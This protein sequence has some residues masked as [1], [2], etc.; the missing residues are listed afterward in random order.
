MAN[1]SFNLLIFLVV[2]C[3]AISETNNITYIDPTLKEL[4]VNQLE[5]L[6]YL[7]VSKSARLTGENLF[8]F[9][10]FSGIQRIRTYTT[11]KIDF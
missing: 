8:D 11:I 9:N 7:K 1:W 3:S 4:A 2:L 5:D 6:Y 10:N